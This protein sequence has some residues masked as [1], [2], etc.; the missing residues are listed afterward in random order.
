MGAGR[1]RD[2]E[3]DL[4]GRFCVVTLVLGF[5][6]VSSQSRLFARQGLIRVQFS[7]PRSFFDKIPEAWNINGEQYAI[8]R[9]IKRTKPSHSN[10]C[11][12]Q[13]RALLR[14]GVMKKKARDKRK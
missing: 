10:P 7:P 11:K 14:L 9:S 6:F 5:G 3:V 4:D 2:G 12:P 1:M 13:K 8:D